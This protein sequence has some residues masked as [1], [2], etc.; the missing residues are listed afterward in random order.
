MQA[1]YVKRTTE[2]LKGRGIIVQGINNKTDIKNTRS[3]VATCK[4]EK[5][6]IVI[7]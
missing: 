7:K 5:K 3:F 1:A 6:K 2:F 4:P